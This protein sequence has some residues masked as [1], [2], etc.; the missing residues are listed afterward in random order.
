MASNVWDLGSWIPALA[1]LQTGTNRYNLCPG[2]SK[3]PRSKIAAESF[4][5][6]LDTGARSGRTC[7]AAI[8]DLELPW[9]LG[10]PRAQVV[11]VCTGAK[12]CTR[13]PRGGV[14][15]ATN[16]RSASPPPRGSTV[17]LRWGSP[18]HKIV[19]PWVG[20]TPYIY[21]YIWCSVARP[22]PLPP[23]PWLPPLRALLCCLPPPA[24]LWC[25]WSGW[26]GCLRGLLN[27]RSSPCGVVVGF[28]FNP[29]PSP[30][31]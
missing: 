19:D 9:T 20:G 14:H 29:P 3:I 31:L 7:T 10:S 24:P 13:D 1:P 5:G 15:P 17:L 30:P 22:L 21:I 6:I 8:L 18:S 28:G 12:A 11:P 25:G 26:C 27:P 16:C 2:G 23:P 4:L